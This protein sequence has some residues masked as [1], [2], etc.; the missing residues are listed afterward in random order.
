MAKTENPNI[1]FLSIDELM[2]KNLPPIR[3]LVDGLVP[4]NAIT[5]LS[6]TSGSFKTWLAMST[7]VAVASGRDFL[8][9]FATQQANVLIIDEESGERLYSE[10]FRLLSSSED[11]PIYLMSMSGF[12][13]AKDKI[14]AVIE[15]C[16]N[17]NIG[18][19]II[20]SLVRINNGDENSSK[21]VASLFA[22]LRAFTKESISVLLI[23]HN[24]KPG[25]AGYDA[26]SDMRGSS[27]IRAAID[28]QLAVR[29]VGESSTIEV[30]QPKNRFAEENEPFKL[31]FCKDDSG[32]IKFIYAGNVSQRGSGTDEAEKLRL[33]KVIIDIVSRY[34]N[35][36]KSAVVKAVANELKISQNKV[37]IEL[38]NMV[39]SGLL[40]TLTGPHNATILNLANNYDDAELVSYE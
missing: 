11:L 25:V 34:Q 39:E 21:D 24:R 37:K 32:K 10:R 31:D 33:Q 15:E 5:I 3:W 2:K 14:K 7:A 28:I 36:N 35:A 38:S 20:D 23:H 40:I 1:K 29:R 9:I 30:R 27:D 8:D 13:A 18:L 17:F 12:S 19:V 6:G 26:S 16:K 4:E 22:H